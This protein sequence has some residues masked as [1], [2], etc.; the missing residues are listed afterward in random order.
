MTST[1]I[2]FYE[3]PGCATNR[4]QKQLLRSAGL[5]LEVRN[6]L[7]EPWTPERLR[8]FFGDRPVVEWFNRSAPAIKYGELDPTQ[9]SASQ[10]LDLM[11]AHPILIRR[12]LISYGSQYMAGF[13]LVKLCTHLPANSDLPE[14]GSER[15]SRSAG[16]QGSIGCLAA[17]SQ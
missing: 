4:L 7:S 8:P 9:L 15:E 2:V 10:A 16:P 5:Q 1:S 14:A 3:K 11:L 6:V 13:D 17:G 12:P